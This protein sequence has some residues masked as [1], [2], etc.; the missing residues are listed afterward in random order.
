[1]PLFQLIGYSALA[2]V[3][4]YLA[5][6]ISTILIGLLWHLAQILFYG[7]LLGAIVWFLYKQGFFDFLRQKFQK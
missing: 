5:Y 7:T 4:L 2:L 1:M 6:V 3:A